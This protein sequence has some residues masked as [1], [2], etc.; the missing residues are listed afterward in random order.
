[1]LRLNFSL[2]EKY[3]QAINIIKVATQHSSG[4]NHHVYTF[5]LQATWL[6]FSLQRYMNKNLVK[7]NPAQGKKSSFFLSPPL[8]NHRWTNIIAS[9]K[10]QHRPKRKFCNSVKKGGGGTVINFS[11]QMR[12]SSHAETSLEHLHQRRKKRHH[13]RER[14]G[15]TDENAICLAHPQKKVFR[16]TSKAENN[17][18]KK[19]CSLKKDVC[20]NILQQELSKC[21]C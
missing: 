13:T 21:I 11:L 14:E 20:T 3:F 15:Q 2:K 7:C 5:F 16:M 4:N 12:L 6:S 8:P 10:N 1:M 9:L 19:M 17:T 18:S